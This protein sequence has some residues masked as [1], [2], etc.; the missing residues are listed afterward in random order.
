M[1]TIVQISH[2]LKGRNEELYNFVVQYL[3]VAIY[4]LLLIKIFLKQIA[5]QQLLQ[6]TEE[7]ELSVYDFSS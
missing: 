6:L 1:K 3:T 2:L 5:D 7:S 4:K